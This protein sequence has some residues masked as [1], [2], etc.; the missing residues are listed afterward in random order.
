MTQTLVS[1]NELALGILKNNNHLDP[2][3]LYYNPSRNKVHMLNLSL[4]SA[5]SLEFGVVISAYIA[6]RERSQAFTLVEI[7]DDGDL[8]VSHVTL[9]S[10]ENWVSVAKILGSDQD[11]HLDIQVIEKLDHPCPMAQV[12]W[13]MQSWRTMDKEM[14]SIC[15]GAYVNIKRQIEGQNT[16]IN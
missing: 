14:I 9:E 12:F 10:K 8:T 1:I 11:T 5:D 4:L 7:D 15:E 6:V 3:T 16:A 13:D 2:M